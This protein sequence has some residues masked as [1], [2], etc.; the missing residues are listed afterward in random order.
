MTNPTNRQNQGASAY[1]STEEL[2]SVTQTAQNIDVAG[3]EMVE[4]V[5]KSASKA[6]FRADTAGTTATA[7][8]TG[9]A[10]VCIQESS[11]LFVRQEKRPKYSFASTADAVQG[12]EPI[13]AFGS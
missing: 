12:V 1:Q 7:G 9:N 13:L 2:I 3:C 8:E 6:Y 10:D 11:R 4:L 5:N